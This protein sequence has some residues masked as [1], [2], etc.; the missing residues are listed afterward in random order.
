M[1]ISLLVLL[2]IGFTSLLTYT[3]TKQVESPMEI[4]NEYVK[5]LIAMVFLVIILIGG[6]YFA[7]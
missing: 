3:I 5:F 6:L 2:S 1:E 7:F 4:A